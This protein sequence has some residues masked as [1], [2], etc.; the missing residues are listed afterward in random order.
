MTHLTITDLSISADLDASAMASVRGG[1]YSGYC[2]PST[3]SYCA[4]SYSG[5]KFDVTKNDFSFNA[6]QTLGQ[7]QNTEVNNGNNVAF[8]SG[9]TSTVNPSQHGSNNINFG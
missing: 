5:P 2:M 1:T 6:A 8:A 7:C 9:I 4:P 3:P